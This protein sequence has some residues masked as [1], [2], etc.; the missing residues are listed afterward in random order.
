MTLE[1]FQQAMRKIN[2]SVSKEDI[3]R[4]EEWRSTYGAS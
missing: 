2:P 1:D 3:K 4:H